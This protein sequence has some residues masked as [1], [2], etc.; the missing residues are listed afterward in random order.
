MGRWP[1]M[2]MKARFVGTTDSKWVMRDFRRVVKDFA[3][4]ESAIRASSQLGN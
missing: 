2:V 4:V 1:I 3:T